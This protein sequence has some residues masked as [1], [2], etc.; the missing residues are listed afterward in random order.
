MFNPRSSPELEWVELCNR[1]PAPLDLTGY[2]FWDDDNGDSVAPNFPA[3]SVVPGGSCVALTGAD[4]VPAFHEAWG[5]DVPVVGLEVFPVLTN[6][7]DRIQ[8]WDADHPPQ[9]EHVDPATDVVFAFDYRGSLG[10]GAA[11]IQLTSIALDPTDPANWQL[12][13][14][15]PPATVTSDGDVGTPGIVP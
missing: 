11:S 12:S 3:D 2:T 6:S 9:P 15:A 13:T 4:D 8:L 7:G 5:A 14:S 10:D 1:A